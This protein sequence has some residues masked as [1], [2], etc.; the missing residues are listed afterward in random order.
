MAPTPLAH[1]MVEESPDILR[2]VA[3]HKFSGIKN[4][5]NQDTFDSESERLGHHEPVGGFATR[6]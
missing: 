3:C 6:R 5:C 2:V 4:L 1:P